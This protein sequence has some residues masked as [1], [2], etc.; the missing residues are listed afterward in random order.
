MP[1]P[2][3]QAS[4]Y[5]KNLQQP[6]AS[7]ART[8]T[9]T[10]STYDIGDDDSF[11][12]WQTVTATIGGTLAGKF[13]TSPDSG[14]TWYDLPGANFSTVSSGTDSQSVAATQVPAK[15]IRYV[16]T[17]AGGG[18]T[19][20][21]EFM[22]Y[23][24]GLR[25]VSST[26]ANASNLTSGTIPTLRL[27]QDIARTASVTIPTASVLDLHDTPYT[28]VAA[29]GAG[30]LV[31]V[32]EVTVKLVF[33]SVAYTGS[34]ALEI[35]YTDGSG[36]KATADIAAAFVNSASGTNYVSVKGVVT[37]LTPVANA[38]IVAVVPVA[39]PGAGNS[40]LVVTVKYRVVT[41]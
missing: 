37:S 24:A 28:L 35:R 41:P 40:A 36:A 2:Q 20:H 4:P 5:Q 34:N 23:K 11:V 6:V 9:V 7:A 26:D 16:G 21:V 17:I 13:Q 3:T 38:G 1:V 10:S 15:K 27:S 22:S 33:N 30:T 32:D 14:T 29:Q 8:S 25:I 31:L 18:F 19:H 39:D 12:A